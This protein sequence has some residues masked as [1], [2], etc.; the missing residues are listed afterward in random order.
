V[1]DAGFPVDLPGGGTEALT[2]A[3]DSS[4]VLWV[5]YTLNGQVFMSH[6]LGSDEE[7]AKASLLPVAEGTTVSSDDTAG[8]VALAG[9]IG[10]FWS[11]QL[12]DTLY[13]AVHE[14]G[15]PSSEWSL[16]VVA[17]G[18]KLADD[19]FNLKLAGDG[20]L[21]AAVKTSQ[22]SQGAIHIGLLVRSPAGAWSGLQPV[23]G[24]NGTPTR[25]LCVLDEVARQVYVF[26]SNSQSAIYYKS[27]DMDAISFPTGSGIPF[28][29]SDVSG[30][31]NNPTGSKQNVDATTGIVVMASGSER[32]WHGTIGVP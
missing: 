32:Y 25:P 5:A 6:S 13:F 12:T 16:E 20:R 14:D 21:F 26:F 29:A 15:A 23:A 30:N 4:G 9:K 24:A 17:N 18:P 2:I 19:H 1:L 3:R 27:S 22:T 11:N 31:I 7:W 10:V 28:I 8:V